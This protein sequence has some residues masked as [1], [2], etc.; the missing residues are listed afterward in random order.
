[1]LCCILFQ[2]FIFQFLIRKQLCASKHQSYC[3]SVCLLKQCL[4][5]NTW[6]QV[7]TWTILHFKRSEFGGVG[8]HLDYQAL[9]DVWLDH[10]PKRCCV[11]ALPLVKNLGVCYDIGFMASSANVRIPSSLKRENLAGATI[12]QL[13]SLEC[14]CVVVFKV[15][16]MRPDLKGM[17]IIETQQL[18]S[19]ETNA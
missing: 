6:A 19:S 15:N 4:H 11:L 7:Q 12:M 17:K 14:T 13:F 10:S 8:Q 18:S 16:Y 9:P 5:S 2:L 1:M 3:W